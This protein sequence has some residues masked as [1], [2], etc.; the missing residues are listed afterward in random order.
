M[1]KAP[2][3]R[4]HFGSS[5]FSYQNA[6]LFSYCG[7]LKISWGVIKTIPLHRFNRQP[8]KKQ[9]SWTMKRSSNI[10]DSN[11]FFKEMHHAIARFCASLRTW[12]LL[13]IV[14]HSLFTI[15][16]QKSPCGTIFLKVKPA[17]ETGEVY[18][19]PSVV[20]MY[21]SFHDALLIKQKGTFR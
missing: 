5:S 13:V 20:L 21:L 14:L 19:L 2:F 12:V 6:L 1:S 4:T 9:L 10:W 16:D 3:L 15:K 18:L 11:I 17:T 8:N 7:A